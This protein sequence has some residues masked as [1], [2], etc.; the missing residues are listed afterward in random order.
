MTK[1]SNKTSLAENIPFH[2]PS[3]QGQQL[4]KKVISVCNLLWPIKNSWL[5]KLIKQVHSK[6]FQTPTGAGETFCSTN[7]RLDSEVLE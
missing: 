5:K 3:M 6:A 7:Y 1:E 4:E 2:S